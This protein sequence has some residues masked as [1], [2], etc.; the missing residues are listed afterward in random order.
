M[1]LIPKARPL[2]KS[3]CL[4]KAKPRILALPHLVPRRTPLKTMMDGNEV[5]KKST[6]RY[7]GSITDRER[8]IDEDFIHR[9]KDGWLIWRGALGILCN[10][11]TPTKLKVKFYKTAVRPA[12]LYV[13]EYW[14]V[15]K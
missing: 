6:F 7:L 5:S 12:M 2:T 9:I 1:G 8:E 10:G 4:N 15:K 11:Q 13:L 3:L 14:A